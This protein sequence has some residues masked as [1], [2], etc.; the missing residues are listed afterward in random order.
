MNNPNL[1]FDLFMGILAVLISGI[2]VAVV[3]AAFFISS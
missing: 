1:K 2:V 3:I